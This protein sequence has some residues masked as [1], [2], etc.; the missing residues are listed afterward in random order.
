[1]LTRKLIARPLTPNVQGNQVKLPEEI[2]STLLQNNAS[3]PYLFRLSCDN[4]STVC[5]VREFTASAEEIEMSSVVMS[6][7]QILPGKMVDCKLESM[8]KGEKI[9]LQPH[10]CAFVKLDEPIKVLQHR[11]RLY[12]C[13]SMGDTIEIM[14]A[15]KLY[16]FD[17]V[18]T[19]PSKYIKIVESNVIVEFMEALDE[20][21]KYL[22]PGF[23]SNDDELEESIVRLSHG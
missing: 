20:P 6:N 14:F 13:L 2:M 10:E 22:P 23:D 11:L 15:D 8:P 17:V 3:F 4:K 21:R 1:M 19:K 18:K 12:Y 16:K 9:V 7:L 5:G